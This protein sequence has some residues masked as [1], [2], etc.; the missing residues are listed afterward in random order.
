MI[1]FLVVEI[2]KLIAKKK[3]NIMNKNYVNEIVMEHKCSDD[4]IFVI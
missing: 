3:N 4:V 1:Y 2:M